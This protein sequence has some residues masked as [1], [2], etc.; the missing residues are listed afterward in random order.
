MA[1]ISPVSIKYMIYASFKSAGPLEKPDVI[2][3][4]FG[5]TEGLLGSDMEMRELQKEGKIGRI[6]VDLEIVDGKSVGEIQVPTAMDKSATTLIAAALET[7]D[8]IGPTEAEIKILKIE[9]VRGNKREY[10]LDR[11]KK[12]MGLIEEEGSFR[13]MS[14]SLKVESRA[15][16]IQ[17]YGDSRLPCGDISGSELIVVEGRADVVNLLRN[18][19]NNVIGM[20]GT[21]LPPE[22]AQLSKEKEIT[23]FVDGD[24]GGKLIANNVIE[25]ANVKFVAVAPEGKEVEELAGKEILQA[26]RKTMTVSEYL[27]ENGNGNSFRERGEKEE[28]VES[29]EISFSGDV[30]EK[31]RKMYSDKLEGTKSALLLD[32]SLDVIRKVGNREIV[33]AVKSSRTKVAALI[34]DGT[35]TSS[36]IRLCDE[37][38]IQ[39]FAATNFASTEGAKVKLVSL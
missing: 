21:K 28:R 24:R 14:E 18:R 20:D 25:H 12:L 13:E 15:E 26:L 39:Y 6:E 35:A 36:L 11:A 31:L 3:A 1:K 37:Q 2:G 29:A 19:V 23:L 38:G 17:E 16:K 9:D 30:K 7:I 33:G 22:I 10:I 4:I 34:L 32:T 8:R 5:Q 27:R